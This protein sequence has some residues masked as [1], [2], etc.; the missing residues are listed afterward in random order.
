MYV[1]R[2]Q[3]PDQN[4]AGNTMVGY[5]PAIY[6]ALVLSPQLIRSLRRIQPLH[7]VLSLR[8]YSARI[9]AGLQAEP[10]GQ[11]DRQINPSDTCGARTQRAPRTQPAPRPTLHH[12]SCSTSAH[13][14]LALAS[15]SACAHAERSQPAT[16]RSWGSTPARN[17]RHMSDDKRERLAA[18]RT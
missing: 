16:W 6:A 5:T 1:T 13:A 18:E 14:L 2:N 11:H 7:L 15:Y 17:C 4:P 12:S 3:Y 8:S 10:S 9:R